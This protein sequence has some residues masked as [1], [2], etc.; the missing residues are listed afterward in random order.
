[1]S[2]SE[3][4]FLHCLKNYY[5]INLIKQKDLVPNA[6]CE[7]ICNEVFKHTPWVDPEAVY[8]AIDWEG[9]VYEF[10]DE[11]DLTISGWVSHMNTVVNCIG[12][13]AG[14]IDTMKYWTYSLQKRGENEDT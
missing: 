10:I 1:M 14:S 3:K 11:P 9:Y 5:K 6:Y 7:I 12:H 4:H 8:R 2:V 13:Y